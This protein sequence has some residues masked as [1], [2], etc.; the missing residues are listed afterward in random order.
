MSHGHCSGSASSSLRSGRRFC[1]TFSGT[2]ARAVQ[3]FDAPVP[4]MVEQL[5]EVATVLTPT[6]I[7]VQIAEQIVGIPVPHAS[8]WPS[9]SVTQQGCN[10]VCVRS[11]DIP[12][13]SGFFKLFAQTGSTAGAARRHP[14]P[15]WWRTKFWSS[16]FFLQRSTAS[17]S[18]SFFALSPRIVEQI[19]TFQ[20]DVFK[21]HLA[22][23]LQL[24]MKNAQMSL[25]K[26]G[27]LLAW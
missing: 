19:V 27:A 18:S 20:V 22:L 11:A 8:S 13:S 23:T 21:V 25:A 12:S 9:A 16:R 1:G 24:V 7:A 15:W 5:V 6:R 17:P 4:Q 3:I 26:P 2:S 10:S 14:V